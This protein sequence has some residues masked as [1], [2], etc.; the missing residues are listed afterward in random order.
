MVALSAIEESDINLPLDL[1]YFRL[2]KAKAE[3]ISI[4]RKGERE[5]IVSESRPDIPEHLTEEWAPR[6]YSV[7]LIRSEKNYCTPIPSS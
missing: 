1:R 5:H 7:G 6:N 3:Q 2:M 4:N